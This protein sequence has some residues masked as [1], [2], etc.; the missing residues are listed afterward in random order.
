MLLLLSSSTTV[1]GINDF[2]VKKIH[3]EGLQ[4]I[5][6]STALM[7]LPIHIGDTINENNIK[8][9]IRALFSTG[10]FKDIQLLQDGTE[11]I[12]RVKEYP[13]IY[14]ITFVGNKTITTEKLKENLEMSHIRIGQPVNNGMLSSIE[15]KLQDVYYSIGK[16]NAKVKVIS[17]PLSYNR[18]NLK[19]SFQEGIS[20]KIQQI[21]IIGN[22]AFSSKQLLSCFQ[23]HGQVAWW[24]IFNNSNY[25][26][27]TLVRDL[28]NLRQFYLDR[29]Y[30]HFNIDSKKVSLTSDK[31]KI[32]ITVHITEGE[33]YKV[34][35]VIIKSNTTEYYAKIEKL[36]HILS[37]RLYNNSKMLKIEN[38]IKNILNTCGYAYPHVVIY[39]EINNVNK[40]VK[41]RLDINTGRRYYVHNV[42]FEGHTISKDAILRREMR[43]MEGTWFSGDLVNKGKERLNRT[44]YFESVVVIKKRVPGTLDQLDVIYQIKERNTGTFNFSIGY[45]TE[46][47]L[48]FQA[49]VT[50]GN[51]LGSGNS[52]SISSLKN[53]YQTYAEFSMTDPYVTIDGVSLGGR[54]FY[55]NFKA[56]K[57]DLSDYTNESYGVEATIG[58]PVSY[59]NKLR[60]GLGYLY[61]DIANIHPQIAMWRY[62]NSLGHHRNFNDKHDV[63]CCDFTFN[64]GWTFNG[65]DRTFFSRHGTY[66]NLNGK[67]SIPG[68]DNSFYKIT[69][70]IRHYIPIN[71]E[72]TWI[73]LARS[74]IGYG[75]G[76][77]SKEMPFYENFYVGGSS[78]VRGFLSR[79]IGPK[80]AYLKNSA[81]LIAKG[82]NRA[83]VSKSNDAIGGNANAIA[84]IEVITPTPF[85]NEKY[86]NV[87][88]TSFFI[89]AGT[90]WDSKWQNNAQ[91]IS[92]GIPDYSD[93]NNIRIS[94][95]MSIQWRSPLGPLTFS[96]AK[97]LRK[98]EGD[99]LEQ[100]QFNI[101]STW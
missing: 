59:S 91:T 40:T 10:N 32:Y 88:R 4:R 44:G 13:T 36:T 28:K 66:S 42:R 9:A 21:N 24:N 14:K 81:N 62:F 45:G 95:G 63:S 25:Y 33:Q 18:I 85:L 56:N 92:A 47:G 15:K 30:I 94:V 83:V 101:G 20:S 17:T 65:L 70:D 43:Q 69:L 8:K 41:L 38:D 49:S 1:F 51:W 96:Y 31:R 80:A 78:T 68:S 39:P 72:R 90:V 75:N 74:R 98:A 27:E 67:I 19:F 79:T 2:V 35:G 11:L 73:I 3:F 34:I 26:R 61:N 100:F 54:L 97:P 57:A 77:G 89:D 48:N 23:L 50:Q 86:I 55:N 58:F 52:V 60:L 7:N 93:P 6:L 99:K 84:S 82:G 46:S 53:D 5:T 64:Y 29:G 16:Y 71:H 22:K 37:N 12:I 76:F 87:I